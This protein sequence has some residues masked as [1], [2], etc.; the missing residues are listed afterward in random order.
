M[1]NLRLFLTAT[2]L[3]I[4]SVTHQQSVGDASVGGTVTMHYSFVTPTYP[5]R[6]ESREL[7]RISAATGIIAL[8][9]GSIDSFLEHAGIEKEVAIFTR[10]YLEP[11][12]QPVYNNDSK[13]MRAIST[14]AEIPISNG[15]STQI[16]AKYRGS[17]D[18]VQH[19]WEAYLTKEVVEK[20]LWLSLGY[21]QEKG[22]YYPH[23][24]PEKDI[25]SKHA[26]LTLSEPGLARLR[27]SYT[28]GK[29]RRDFI[30]ISLDTGSERFTPP[31]EH[32]EKRRSIELQ[33]YPSNSLTA[34]TEFEDLSFSVDSYANYLLATGCLTFDCPIPSGTPTRHYSHSFIKRS[35]G[36]DLYTTPNT[37]LSFT[38][39]RNQDYASNLYSSEFSTNDSRF[40]LGLQYDSKQNFL[41]AS[42]RI[43]LGKK[44]SLL[45]RDREATFN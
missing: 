40:N 21:E 29:G 10:T 4:L 12:T 18:V 11:Q 25:A 2:S 15:F 9:A 27:G 32:K 23:L 6:N 22:E 1:S 13:Y 43:N 19:N 36:V 38:A 7:S 30:D 39:I 34:R 37:K 16:Y 17:D 35:H 45:S 24:F 41:G 33:L 5:E 8:S 28:Q 44:K 20:K 3:A 42:V 31:D 14:G 26:I